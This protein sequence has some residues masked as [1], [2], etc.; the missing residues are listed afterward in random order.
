MDQCMV[1]IGLNNPDVKRWDKAIIFG[2][3][4]SGAV[5]DASDIAEMTGTISYEIMTAVSKR[6]PRIIQ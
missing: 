2:S 6:V 5:M 1:D 4:E 3:K